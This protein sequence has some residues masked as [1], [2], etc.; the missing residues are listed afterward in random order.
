M[1]FKLKKIKLFK[2][3]V[4]KMPVENNISSLNKYSLIIY[5]I[6]II[7]NELSNE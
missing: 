7:I 4:K 5:I 1:N 6:N 2:N 3:N